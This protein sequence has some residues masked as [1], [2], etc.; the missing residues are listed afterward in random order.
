MISYLN[1][2]AD[3]ELPMRG[4]ATVYPAAMIGKIIGCQM[5]LLM[6]L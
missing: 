4:Y 1:D 2:Q 6:L 3:T 5:L